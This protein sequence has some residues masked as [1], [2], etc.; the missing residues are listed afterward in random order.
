MEYL[1][2]GPAGMGMFALAG[3]LLKYEDELK[4]IKEISGSSAGAILAVALALRIPL[5]D[6][7]DRLLALDFAN[8]TKFKIKSFLSSFGFA[9]MKPMRAA[10]VD[11]YGCD[12]TFSELKMKIYIAS[13]CINRARTEYFSVDTH[14]NMKVIDAVC[15]SMAIPL[16]ISSVEYNGMIYMDGGTKELIPTT[17]FV[18]K[19]PEKIM[20][21]RVKHKDVYID[22]IKNIRQ[23]L[24]G[25]IVS[26][27]QVPDTNTLAMG[28][29]V[30]LDIDGEDVLKFN[31]TH[32]E[33]LKLFMKGTVS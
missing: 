2:L 4:N 24:K 1:V 30:E 18:G 20:C 12:P 9:D 15:M 3:S 27:L 17:P 16:V 19:K 21:I 28:K 6:V 25:I 26:V 23:F 5:H 10:L 14:P 13:Y 7:L 31:M 29:V 8:L 33:K 11:A 32:E 22:K